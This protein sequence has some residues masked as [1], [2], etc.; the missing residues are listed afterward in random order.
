MTLPNIKMN[1]DVLHCLNLKVTSELNLKTNKIVIENQANG[2][3]LV[4][5]NTDNQCSRRSY[6]GDEDN[7]SV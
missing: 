2:N 1:Y 7:H 6:Q 5:C 4:Y 3:L